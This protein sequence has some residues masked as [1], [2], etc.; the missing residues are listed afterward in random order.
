MSVILYLGIKNAFNAINHQAIFSIFEACCFPE[1]DIALLRRMYTGSF[2]VMKNQFGE[3]AACMLSR[4]AMQGAQPSPRIYDVVSNPVQVLIRFLKR[5]WAVGDDIDPSGASVFA[6]ATAAKTN[7]P[8]AVP[9]MCHM[10][11]IVCPVLEWTCQLVQTKNPK[12]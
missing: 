11:Q 1:A 5:K 4:G 12:S 3:S 8:N 2:L 6:D 10:V 7:G 9:A